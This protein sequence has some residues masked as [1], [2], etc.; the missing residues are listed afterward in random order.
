MTVICRILTSLGFLLIFWE[1]RLSSIIRIAYASLSF[2][3][4]VCI[5]WSIWKFEY[6]E[7]NRFTVCCYQLASLQIP[8]CASILICYLLSFRTLVWFI[9]SLLV[10]NCRWSLSYT[11]F[12]FFI[13]HLASAN[14]SAHSN[15][16]GM[17]DEW[18]D[19]H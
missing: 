10:G 14:A 8:A 19:L 18:Q 15:R 13:F 1:W 17:G 9:G 4:S 2:L 12:F 11:I 16:L 3:C 6:L 5:L 7:G